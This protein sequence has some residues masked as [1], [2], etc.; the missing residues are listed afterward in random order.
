[1]NN[2]VKEVREKLGL[3]QREMAAQMQCSFNT[4]RRCEYESRLPQTV[5]VR[6]RFYKLAKKAG[7]SIE[8][9]AK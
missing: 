8:V 4:A 2:S 1:M 9:E 5:A 7:V 6:E 3:T